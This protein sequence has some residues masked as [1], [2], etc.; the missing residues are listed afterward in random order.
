MD[1]KTLIIIILV[2]GLFAGGNA[3]NFCKNLAGTDSFLGKWCLAL[4]SEAMDMTEEFMPP[5][6]ELNITHEIVIDDQQ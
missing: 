5:E 1:K 4:T 6:V 3:H 2:V